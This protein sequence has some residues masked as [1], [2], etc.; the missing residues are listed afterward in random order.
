MSVSKGRV[1]SGYNEDPIQLGGA[2]FRVEGAPPYRPERF[3]DKALREAME[4]LPVGV[5][6]GANRYDTDDEHVLHLWKDGQS[7][8]VRLPKPS[9]YD[10][11]AKP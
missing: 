8:D 5:Y 2:G 1:R 6:E 11:E 3:Q 9:L 4:S 7:W 10:E